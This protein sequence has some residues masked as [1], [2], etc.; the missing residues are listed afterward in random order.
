MPFVY[1]NNAT[2]SQYRSVV[3][4]LPEEKEATLARL[5]SQLDL[6]FFSYKAK[7]PSQALGARYPFE[8]ITSESGRYVV[9]LQTRR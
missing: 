7:L 1:W 6:D 8:S 9:Y 2:W 5:L 3:E 4:G